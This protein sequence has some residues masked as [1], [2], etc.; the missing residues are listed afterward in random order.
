MSEQSALDTRASR[1]CAVLTG[2][3]LLGS[4]F[5]APAIFGGVALFPI[6]CVVLVK[7]RRR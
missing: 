5:W 1:I 6:W 3:S 7:A 2:V 4:I